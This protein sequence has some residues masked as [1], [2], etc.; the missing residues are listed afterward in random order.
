MLPNHYDPE[1]PVMKLVDREKVYQSAKQWELKSK[2]FESCLFIINHLVEFCNPESPDFIEGAYQ[3]SKDLAEFIY[4]NIHDIEH[5]VLVRNSEPVINVNNRLFWQTKT[6][7]DL[8][9][10]ETINLENYLKGKIVISDKVY[11]NIPKTGHEELNNFIK[12]SLENLKS[13]EENLKVRNFRGIQ[14]SVENALLPIVEEAVFFHSC[15]T[16]N[17]PSYETVGMHPFLNCESI[18]TPVM[19]GGIDKLFAM[20]KNQ[21]LNKMEKYNRILFSGQ[22]VKLV[23]SS[24]RDLVKYRK[25]FG[26]KSIVLNKCSSFCGNGAFGVEDLK[27]DGVKFSQDL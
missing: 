20:R 19:H 14:G 22:P 3:E 13:K 8:I 1:R 10:G 4:R 5:I 2:K 11:K 25:D 6:G 15:V 18:F 26:M 27:E 16:G 12:I 24:V 7:K 23:L 17:L 9:V 21:L